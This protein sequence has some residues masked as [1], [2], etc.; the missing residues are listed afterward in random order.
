MAWVFERA[1]RFEVTFKRLYKRHRN[2]CLNA[3][4]N[5]DLYVKSLQ[6][7]AKPSQLSSQGFVHNEGEGAYAVDQRS[8]RDDTKKPR[9]VNA[10]VRLYFYP[11]EST[12][13]VHVI[14]IGDKGSQSRDVK[15]VHQYVRG[16][17]SASESEE[18]NG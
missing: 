6:E 2:E 10:Q 3:L 13:T 11:D 14:L 5:L 18:S 12:A 4:D 17:K 7:G 16:I 1:S 8:G 9:K 15:E